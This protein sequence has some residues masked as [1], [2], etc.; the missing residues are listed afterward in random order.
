MLRLA[1][2]KQI[3]QLAKRNKFLIIN[4]KHLLTKTP[5]QQQIRFYNKQQ[6]DKKKE[7]DEEADKLENLSFEK[8]AKKS[9]LA[10]SLLTPPSYTDRL[11]GLGQTVVNFSL[12]IIKMIPGLLWKS[13]VFTYNKLIEFIRNPAVVKDWY[14]YMKTG[15]VNFLHHNWVGAKLL[16]ADI[17]T[18]TKLLKKVI[19]GVSLTRREKNQLLATV[20]DL[21]RLVP[22]LFFLV[23]PMLE[24]A[25]P[26]AIKLFPN[27]LPR[28][29]EDEDAKKIKDKQLKQTLKAK[30]ALAKFLQDTVVIMANDLKQTSTEETKKTAE[31]LTQFMRKVKMGEKVHN[32][33]LAKFSKFFSD[34]ITLD[35]ISRPQLVA[36]CRFLGLYEY[37]TDALLRYRLNT[38]LGRIKADDRYIAWE[39]VKS[40]ST[41]ELVL[42]CT[43]RGIKV[44]VPKVELQNQ[45][46]SWIKLS[47][48]Q[49]IPPTLLILSR[50]FAFTDEADSSEAIK[51]TIGS[52][53]ESVVKQVGST[54][55]E[56]R[57]E[58]LKRQSE[59]IEEELIDASSTTDSK[60]EEA[61]KIN[62]IREAIASASQDPLAIEKD[63]VEDLID[64]I[65]LISE[66]TDSPELLKI[67]QRVSVLLQQLEE[68]IDSFDEK[69]TSEQKEILQILDTKKDGNISVQEIRD[70]LKGPLYKDQNFTD[71]QVEDIISKIDTDH[72]GTVSLKQLVIELKDAKKSIE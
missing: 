29:F 52:L 57:L 12:K 27:M 5:Y 66:K 21:F 2:N 22:L 70:F 1:K 13:L 34:E 26:F 48:D 23:V 46:D 8:M 39:G 69:M 11:K 41:E 60:K 37:G 30:L 55:N 71:K 40:L 68:N 18:S 42:A 7:E 43:E 28:Q 15:T 32:E 44:S 19:R 24:F 17:K 33:E 38:K 9:K 35:N 4:E 54:D 62:E 10:G 36:M 65:D 6:E 59:L 20:S 50:I 72:D 53:S 3:L 64:D 16:Y 63:Q 14:Q 61:L 25:L 49:Q 45:L 47:L 31:E 67:T 56:S 51:A 58:K